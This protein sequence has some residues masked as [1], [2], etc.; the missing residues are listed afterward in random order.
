MASTSDWRVCGKIGVALGAFGA[1]HT[2]LAYRGTK[3]QVEK[4]VGRERYSAWYRLFYNAQALLATIALVRYILRQPDREI[5][6]VKGFLKWLMH[7]VQVAAALYCA[8]AVKDFGFAR[9]CGFTDVLA[10]ANPEDKAARELSP[11]E[12]Q[13]PTMDESGHLI[14]EGAFQY[15][16]HPLN[17]A[18]FIVFWMMPRL[19]RNGLICNIL[20]SLYIVAGSLHEEKRLREDY[21]AAYE[22]Y[23]KSG[24]PFLLPRLWKPKPNSTEP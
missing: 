12:S 8:W 22:R 6:E 16:R 3:Q 24:V 10:W 20:G 18:A 17:V 5:Y 19:T 1:F 4:L 14:T 11:R 7:A 2:L 15:S 23:Q 9:F 21:G 13:G